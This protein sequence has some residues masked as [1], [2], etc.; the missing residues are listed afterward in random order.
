MKKRKLNNFD[1]SFQVPESTARW[2]NNNSQPRGSDVP[3][4]P[5][6]PDEPVNGIPCR[7]K[8][9]PVIDVQSNFEHSGD[10]DVSDELV[11]DLEGPGVDCDVIAHGVSSRATTDVDSEWSYLD[12][13]SAMQEDD[14]RVICDEVTDAQ[15]LRAPT[16]QECVPEAVFSAAASSTDCS[17]CI[18]N[19][20]KQHLDMRIER[21][22]I[23]PV[24]LALTS[25]PPALRMS[26]SNLILAGIWLGP[27]K[28]KMEMILQPV[29]EKLDVYGKKGIAISTDGGD[30]II[31]DS[32]VDHLFV[33]STSP[34]VV[35]AQPS[36]NAESSLSPPES[37]VT[38]TRILAPVLGIL[39]VCTL[40]CTGPALHL[41]S[42]SQRQAENGDY[43]SAKNSS[44]AVAILL[45]AAVT[46]EVIL[47]I[48]IF[49][50]VVLIAAF[51]H[52]ISKIGS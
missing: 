46:F 50:V 19:S 21:Q 15:D 5:D 7:L 23:W 2:Q 30:K 32:E 28:P 22:S 20:T 49:V 12:V 39:G 25:L 26:V 3:D 9:Y 4:V 47:V 48:I 1:G 38:L 34:Q 27:V 18:V 44:T 13:D 8:G 52:A 36:S 10:C 14:V 16:M 51:L 31:K 33:T 29:L 24:M 37:F 42:V 40:F 41:S 35:I 6:V 45:V 17:P 43:K 11:N